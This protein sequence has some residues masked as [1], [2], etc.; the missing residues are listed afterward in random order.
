MYFRPARQDKLTLVLQLLKD[1]AL[2]LQEKK[3]DYWQNW[4]NPPTEFVNWIKE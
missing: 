3:I 2:W 4:I 1:A